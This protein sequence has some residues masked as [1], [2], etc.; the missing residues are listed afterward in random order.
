[1]TSGTIFRWCSAIRNKYKET[2]ETRLEYFRL[3]IH[4]GGI[5][6]WPSKRYRELWY[7]SSEIITREIWS[8]IS[9]VIEIATE[10]CRIRDVMRRDG[11][12]ELLVRYEEKDNEDMLNIFLFFFQLQMK[13]GCSDVWDPS[14][15]IICNRLFW[16][17][18]EMR[19]VMAPT[20]IHL[21]QLELSGFFRNLIQLSKENTIQNIKSS[22][23]SI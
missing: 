9:T 12:I 19:A 3:I 6:C 15:V 22:F 20:C 4:F 14:I 16:F 7:Y 13:R 11:G 21:V 8:P 23:L 2:L 18:L 17:G 5:G 1:M 10:I